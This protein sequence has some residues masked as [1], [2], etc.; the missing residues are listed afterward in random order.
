[1]HAFP[2]TSP[3][4]IHTIAFI[5]LFPIVWHI[6]SKL[7]DYLR[8]TYYLSKIPS[9]K[10]GLPFFG[11]VFEMLKGSPWDTM[12]QWVLK[13]GKIYKFSLFGSNAVV[14]ADP[15]LLKIVLK[16][17]FRTFK[18]D[19]EWTY[20]PFLVILGNG[21]VTSDGKDWE[22]QR[23]LLA[24]FLLVDILDV[25]PD[26]AIRAV[27]RLSKKLDKAKIDGTLLHLF[28]WSYLPAHYLNFQG[29]TIEMAEEFRNLTLQ[30]IAEAVLSLSPEESDETF[31]RMYLP[32]VEEGN[33]RTW[34]PERMYMPGPAM[35]K[36]NMDVKRLNDYVTSLIV[37]RWDL[38]QAEKK[39]GNFISSLLT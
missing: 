30:V 26:M 23:Q 34:H 6:I 9:V 11:M 22:R 8:H 29:T 15:E 37:K 36:F 4:V 31:A 21:L 13:Y 20:Q 14:V 27:N 32:I 12:S 19:L 25:I 28:S 3:T 38:K 39:E 7:K 5:I 35:Y 24:H 17:E 2:G 10:G 18:K 1:M 33:L 16:E